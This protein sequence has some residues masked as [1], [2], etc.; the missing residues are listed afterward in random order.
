MQHVYLKHAKTKLT[1]FIF[2]F[3]S[4]LRA[5][6][7]ALPVPGSA[8]KRTTG[9]KWSKGGAGFSDQLMDLR[10]EMYKLAEAEEIGLLSIK[11]ISAKK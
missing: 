5:R 9:I 10:V 2:T 4:I 7:P 6:A 3:L 1:T 8:N 11:F